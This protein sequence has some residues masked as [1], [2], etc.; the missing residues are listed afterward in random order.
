MTRRALALLTIVL[1]TALLVALAALA[2]LLPPV[3][4]DGRGAAVAHQP[5]SRIL[6][7]EPAVVPEDGGNDHYW[8]AGSTTSHPA[9]Y[10]PS[11]PAGVWFDW[12]QHQGVGQWQPPSITL[13]S[14]GLDQFSVEQPWMLAVHTSEVWLDCEVRGSNQQ[15]YIRLS[16]VVNP[17]SGASGQAQL[18]PGWR[19]NPR[20][21]LSMEKAGLSYDVERDR[22]LFAGMLWEHSGWR[23]WECKP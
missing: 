5:F 6:T 23:N 22:L 7:V 20:G 4:S 18:H 21:T 16:E 13:Y 8:L 12:E 9:L 10:G 17:L 3:R 1:L 11:I 15:P 19:T 14:G 2:V